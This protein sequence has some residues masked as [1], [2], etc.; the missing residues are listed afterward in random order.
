MSCLFQ[1]NLFGAIVL[2]LMSISL[3]SPS[4]A[5]SMLRG[6]GEPPQAMKAPHS[7]SQIPEYVLKVPRSHFVGISAPC[8]GL[9]EAR[10]S[11]LNDVLKQI[12]KA[13]GANCSLIYED[14]LQTS[15]G[16]AE[17]TLRDSL[18]IQATWFFREI[19]QE[20]VRSDYVHDENQH[21]IFFTLVRYP[22]WKLERMRVLT[23]GPR[24]T[25]RIVEKNVDCLTIQ[26]IES[27]GASVTLT[28]Y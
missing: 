20:I 5:E 23:I 13:L 10:T 8:R 7:I 27:G 12:L 2:V 18:S 17:R 11:S 25:A 9:I 19:E 22:S 6:P 4:T 1:T 28:D 16:A 24:I 15:D 21:Y 26:V 14:H 3:P